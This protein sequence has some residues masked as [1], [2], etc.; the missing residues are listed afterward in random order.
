MNKYLVMLLVSVVSVC[1]MSVLAYTLPINPYCIRSNGANHTFGTVRGNGT[2]NH[3]GH[4]IDAANG[5]P[6]YAVTD[7][8][9]TS[10][11]GGNYGLYVI[12]EGRDY[13]FFYAHLSK[14]VKNGQVKEGDVI[15]LTGSGGNA[16][17]MG[18]DETHLHFEVRLEPH[19]GRGLKGRVSPFDVLPIG[20]K[21][22]TN[23]EFAG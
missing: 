8:Y 10:G 5:T 6:A 1:N 12:L 3:Q 23:C 16:K 18:Y 14:V 21:D 17:G 4:D 19:P 13:Y 11:V 22:S 15:A 9:V 7:G 20:F 2:I